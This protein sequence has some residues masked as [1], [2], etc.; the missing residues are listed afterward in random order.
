MQPV[1]MQGTKPNYIK[2]LAVILMMSMH[3]LSTA[4]L[5]RLLIQLSI[6]HCIANCRLRAIA[7]RLFS[8]PPNGL[9]SS[10][11]YPMRELGSAPI[12][13]LHRWV[14]G[15]PLADLRTNTSLA[16]GVPRIKSITLFTLCT[17]GANLSGARTGWRH[18]G[19]HYSQS[20]LA[21]HS[22]VPRSS[23]GSWRYRP[24]H[25][26]RQSRTPA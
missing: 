15:P 26:S 25:P 5:A 12:V 9:M 7:I 19:P 1:M 16:S 24:K 20:A 21:S 3:K 10:R 22:S 11:C 4:F 14:F 6:A 8:S 17:F 23:A 13:F 2:R 18:Q